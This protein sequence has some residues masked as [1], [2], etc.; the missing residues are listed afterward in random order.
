MAFV[1]GARKL[2]F[3]VTG[4]PFMS[5]GN[6]SELQTSANARESRWIQWM[7]FGPEALLP[8]EHV[9]THKVSSKASR[10]PANHPLVSRL[11][12]TSSDITSEDAEILSCTRCEMDGSIA[13]EVRL[14]QEYVDIQKV[15]R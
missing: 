3:G 4:L 12:L 8:R 14:K 7:E 10:V 1:P 6:T 9:D 13:F 11:S 2:S 15:R 5:R